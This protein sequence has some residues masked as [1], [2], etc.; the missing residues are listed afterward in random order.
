M[1][2][3]DFDYTDF[4]LFVDPHMALEVQDQLKAAIPEEHKE[5]ILSILSSLTR[6][7]LLFYSIGKTTGMSMMLASFQSAFH[8]TNTEVHHE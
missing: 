3:D 4:A 7:D 2:N 6:R 5:K 1:Q 8:L